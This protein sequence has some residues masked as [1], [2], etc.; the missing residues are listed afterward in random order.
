[1]HNKRYKIIYFVKNGI[2]CAGGVGVGNQHST[3]KRGAIEHRVSFKISKCKVLNHYLH[4]GYWIFIWE[5]NIYIS[6]ICIWVILWICT[7]FHSS[8]ENSPLLHMTVGGGFFIGNLNDIRGSLL[9]QTLYTPLV[10]KEKKCLHSNGRLQNGLMYL[11]WAYQFN[12]INAS[13][14]YKNHK[15]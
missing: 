3:W 6:F 10:Y 13:T 7:L 1:M 12:V 2:V 4:L 14:K 11:Y 9:Y 15:L 5:C 8:L